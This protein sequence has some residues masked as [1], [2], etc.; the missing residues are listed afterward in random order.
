LIDVGSALAGLGL[1]IVLHCWML[2]Q[3]AAWRNIQQCSIGCQGRAW[4]CSV[5]GTSTR[6]IQDW[7]GKVIGTSRRSPLVNSLPLEQE[8]KG[9]QVAYLRRCWQIHML[10]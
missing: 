2:H 5:C 1:G 7:Q 9:E 3:A 6:R 8:E 10:I 4:C